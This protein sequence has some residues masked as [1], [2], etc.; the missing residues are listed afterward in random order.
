MRIITCEMRRNLEPF[1]KMHL[2]LRIDAVLNIRIR[3]FHQFG[4]AHWARIFP[5]LAAVYVLENGCVQCHHKTHNLKSQGSAVRFGFP[6]S[7]Y[8]WQNCYLHICDPK[9]LR[10]Y[11]DML[12]T[13]C[14]N[15]IISSSKC[16]TVSEFNC[17]L[18]L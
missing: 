5:Q 10:I 8:Q 14:L 6:P 16:S 1:Q 13:N 17:H 11:R 4:D 18:Q 7:C 2:Q 12:S 9:I 3:C 15:R